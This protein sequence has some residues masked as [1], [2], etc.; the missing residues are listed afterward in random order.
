MTFDEAY[1]HAAAELDVVR[2]QARQRFEQS[3]IDNHCPPEDIDDLRAYERAHMAT[4]RET[5]LAEIGARL[6]REMA[7][8]DVPQ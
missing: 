7:G 6:L 8:P 3:L 4:W 5:R 2:E 1:A